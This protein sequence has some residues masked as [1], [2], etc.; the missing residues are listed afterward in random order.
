MKEALTGNAVQVLWDTGRSKTS[1]LDKLVS[2]LKS[3]YSGERQAEKYRAELQIRRRRCHESLSDLHQNIRRIMALAYQRLTTEAREEIEVTLYHY[4]NALSDPD[5][6]LKVKERTPKSLDEALDVALRLEAWAKNV[7]HS[8]QDE[9]R[10]K[11]PRQKARAAAKSD[12]TKTSSTSEPDD[13]V[14]K[15]ETAMTEIRELLNKMAGKP[16]SL[17]KASSTPGTT[18]I[19]FSSQKRRPRQ[20]L[21]SRKNHHSFRF[22]EKPLDDLSCRMPSNLS[23]HQSFRAWSTWS[24]TQHFGKPRIEGFPR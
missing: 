22:K 16:V 23:I 11:D 6:A 5:F 2:V 10:P 15:L 24:S 7:G 12:N 20:P 4:T 14:T 1:S 13:Q 3:R 21:Q 19:H 8:R 18:S 9:E 17:T